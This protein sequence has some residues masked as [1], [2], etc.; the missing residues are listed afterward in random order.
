MNFLLILT[1]VFILF[2]FKLPYSEPSTDDLLK[3]KIYD[4]DMMT[5][6][7]LVGI[8]S[9]KKQDI[10]EG[11]VNKIQYF[12]NFFIISTKISLG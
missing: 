8:C 1:I 11:K 9:L 12:Y 4:F 6:D 5:K 7:E 10:L 2:F 3:I